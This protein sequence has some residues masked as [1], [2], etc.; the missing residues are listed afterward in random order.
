[1]FPDV[2]IAGAGPAGSLTALLL[3]RA[4]VRVRMVD[5]AAFPRDKLCGDTVNPGAMAIL[6]RHG[7]AEV[8]EAGSVPVN[9][10][11]VTG[12]RGVRIEGDYGDAIVGRALSRRA[13]DVLLV[14]AAVGAGAA[15]EPRVQVRGPWVDDHG[16]VGGLR[17]AGRDGR[18]EIVRAPLTIGAE[19]RRSALG[20]ALGLTWH[21][22]APRRWA[23]GAYFTDV[24]GLTRCGEMHIRRGHYIGVAPLG[25]GVTNACLVL[26]QGARPAWAFRE[27][28][29]LLERTLRADALLAARFAHARRVSPPVLL[30]P[31]AVDARAAGAPGLLLA[32]DAAG[33]IDPMTGDGLRFAFRGAEL[34]AQV[35][36]EAL[37][38]TM[39]VAPHER[40]ARLR[41]AEFGAK[42]RIDH[43]LR[44]LVASPHAVSAAALAAHAWPGGIR[45][46]IRMAGDV[47]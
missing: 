35:A 41:A 14:E 18:D 32:G 20:A 44:A 16:R 19:G 29:A 39:A 43:A 33:F 6:R 46:I 24:A 7:L 3:A 4:G 42:W 15:F 28:A 9:G 10:M 5:R 11:I 47:P 31:L 8:V 13:L 38:S 26:P 12:E 34:A 1:M 40:L 30:G 45:R 36:I 25:G 21:P 23:L 27:T 37:A 17:L 22:R 2:L